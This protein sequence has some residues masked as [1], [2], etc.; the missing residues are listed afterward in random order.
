MGNFQH[1]TR[2]SIMRRAIPSAMVLFYLC[3][4]VTGLYCRCIENTNHHHDHEHP[5]AQAD[6]KTTINHRHDHVDGHHHPSQEYNSPPHHS[7]SCDGVENLALVSSSETEFAKTIYAKIF[8]VNAFQ[9]ST[10]FSFQKFKFVTANY[11]GPPPQLSV[12]LKNQTFLI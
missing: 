1:Q 7:C 5:V 3:F 9:V 4:L 12:Y 10:L 6:A 8:S 2:R 11:H